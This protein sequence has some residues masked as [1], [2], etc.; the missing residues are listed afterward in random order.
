M[1]LVLLREKKRE[2]EGEKRKARRGLK[3]GQG[4]QSPLKWV[5]PTLK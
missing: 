5:N 1:D 3:K 4:K 2:K